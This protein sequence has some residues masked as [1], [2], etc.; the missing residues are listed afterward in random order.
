MMTGRRNL[1][2]LLGRARLQ[3][4]EYMKKDRA[5]KEKVGRICWGIPKYWLRV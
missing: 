1:W 5:V 2:G 4:R 3:E